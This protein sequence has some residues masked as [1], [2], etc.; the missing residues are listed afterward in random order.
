MAGNLREFT[1]AGFDA[2]VMEK[3][4]DEYAGRMVIGKMDVQDHPQT[5]GNF[6]IMGI[7][8]L[9]FIKDGVVVGQMGNANEDKIREKIEDVLG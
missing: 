5:A 9:L 7:P 8:A 1:D 2:D 6:G 3:L 4:A